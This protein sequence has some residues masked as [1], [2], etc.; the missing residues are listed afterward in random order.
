MVT[1]LDNPRTVQG[2]SFPYR[3]PYSPGHTP[4]PTPGPNVTRR[5]ADG[6][7]I[8]AFA[9][10]ADDPLGGST[11]STEFPNRDDGKPITQLGLTGNDYYAAAKPYLN[12]ILPNSGPA[13]LRISG[14]PDP[15]ATVWEVVNSGVLDP[16]TLLP[17]SLNGFFDCIV[18]RVLFGAQYK[19]DDYGA[20]DYHLDFPSGW[21]VT[22]STQSMTL[23][24]ST[25]T[26]KV[27]RRAAGD[28]GDG[29]NIFI[30]AISSNGAAAAQP[31]AIKFYEASKAALVAAGGHYDQRHVD[32]CKRFKVLRYMDWQNTNYRFD[33]VASQV[34]SRKSIFRGAKGW[35][36][37]SRYP[38]YRVFGVPHEDIFEFARLTDTAAWVHCP[39]FLGAPSGLCDLLDQFSSFDP[40]LP[41]Y[42]P[43]LLD[44]VRQFAKDNAA[45]IIASNEWRLYCDAMV[46]AMIAQ[47]YPLN[48]ALYFA[49]CNEKWNP[50][51]FLNFVY[52]QGLGDALVGQDAGS[53]AGYGYMVAHLMRQMDAALAAA[54]RST[55]KFRMMIE[56]QSATPSTLSAAHQ[57][58]DKYFADRALDATPYR[59]RTGASAASYLDGCFKYDVGVVSPYPD[60]ASWETAI[61]ARIAADPALL[62]RQFRDWLINSPSTTDGCVAYLRLRRAQGKAIAEAWGQPYV[63]DYEAGMHT[64]PYGSILDPVIAN[65]ANEWAMSAECAAALTAMYQGFLVDDPAIGI[66][67]FTD[68]GFGTAYDASGN[69][70]WRPPW[71]NPYYGETGGQFDAIL[72]YL[73]NVA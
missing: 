12:Q 6:W 60:K 10:A 31:G 9:N 16:E 66:T 70:E 49:L 45:T 35:R 61:K 33:R 20:R 50:T 8:D 51:F 13:T 28:R 53:M 48:Y 26:R 58:F 52:A 32:Y 40:I 67:D 41:D 4:M 54:G 47:N 64:I 46:A 17:S 55:Q 24:S 65:W 30:N 63:C 42:Q 44:Q 21:D 68:V 62:R 15:V 69:V 29:G 71:L 34:A 14:R 22:L 38:A 72:P 36:A 19:P 18:G 57:G 37:W 39:L 56:Y 5:F 27:Y 23:V 43:A 73:R 2:R 3:R 1:W 25:A 11:P 7:T 59:P